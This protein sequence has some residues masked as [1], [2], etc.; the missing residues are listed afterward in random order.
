MPKKTALLVATC[1]FSLIFQQ[2]AGQPKLSFKLIV[3]SFDA[4]LGIVSAYDGSGRLFI[5]GKNGTIGIYKNGNVSPRPFLNMTSLVSN[6]GEAGMG[7][8]VFHPD[9]T[10]NGYFFVYY[11][12]LQGYITLSRWKVSA[13]DPD[14]ADVNSEVILFSVE[15]KGG[16]TNHNG[17]DLHFGRDG[18]LYIS[19]GDGGSPGDSYNNAQNGLSYFGK[20]LRLNV[21]GIETPPYYSVPPG[22]PFIDN[23]DFLPEVF[24]LGLRNPWRWSFD[25][26]NGNMWLPDVGQDSI[27]EVNFRS[28]TEMAGS[29]YGWHCY[30]GNLVYNTDSCG[31][32]A[33]YVFPVVEFRHDDTAGGKSIIGGYVYRGTAYPAL[34]GYYFC[35][36]F[37][38]PHA[39][40]LKQDANNNWLVTFQ[41]EDVPTFISSIGEDESGELYVTSINGQIYQVEAEVTAHAILNSFNVN[42]FQQTV[43]LTWETLAEINVASFELEFSEDAIHFTHIAFVAP[44][45]NQSGNQYVYEHQPSETG[46]LYYRLAMHNTDGTTI[47]SAIVPVFFKPKEQVLV[48]P[49]IYTGGDLHILL[50]DVFDGMIIYDY[51]GWK[52]FE[53]DLM[54]IT[55][56]LTIQIPIAAS[57]MYLVYFSGERPATKRIWLKN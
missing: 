8:L 52:I 3:D 45:N 43:K 19:T 5:L 15:K 47:Y 40:L 25:R 24:A 4:P 50:N 12:N 29:N 13:A 32:M 28:P 14:S 22:N 55:G 11:I 35:A 46:T 56:N 23:P 53:K 31:N 49:T 30:E 44:H 48:Y 27:E 20:I 1:I 18:Y 9:Y 37:I 21:T 26:D 39:W 41:G 2:V 16:Y 54:G 33:N 36:D 51:S 42:P 34:Q 57:G 7:G 17:G 6:S 10:S 38:F